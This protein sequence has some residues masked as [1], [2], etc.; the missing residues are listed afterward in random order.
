[1]QQPL[2]PRRKYAS[3]VLYAHVFTA[4]KKESLFIRSIAIIAS[5]GNESI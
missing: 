2:F 1:M 3:L 5:P 4:Y